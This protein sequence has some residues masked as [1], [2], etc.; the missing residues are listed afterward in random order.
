MRPLRH[1]RKSSV[2]AI[3]AQTTTSSPRTNGATIAA[4]IV[5]MIHQRVGRK[6]VLKIRKR[7]SVEYGYA[8]GSS[9]IIDEYAIAGIAHE[10]AAT[11]RAGVR[12]TSCRASAYAGKAVSIMISTAMYFT[13]A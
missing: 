4:A 3:T 5:P 2:S 8:S 12:P 1:A 7:Q 13:V 9:T 10:A 6:S 11:K